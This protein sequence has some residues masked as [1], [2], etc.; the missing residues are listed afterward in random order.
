MHRGYGDLSI[1]VAHLKGQEVAKDGGDCVIAHWDT[2][3]EFCVLQK[4]HQCVA[5]LEFP[6]V[7]MLEEVRKEALE[8]CHQEL[9]QL[10]DLFFNDH[11]KGREIVNMYK[12]AIDL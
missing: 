12:T 9:Q 3:N 4:S 1:L 6:A 7:K 2:A 11:S 8:H 10:L 5:L